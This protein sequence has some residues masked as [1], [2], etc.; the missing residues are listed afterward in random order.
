M[1]SQER[2]TSR[3]VVR[4]AHHD[5][6]AILNG[7]AWTIVV[8]TKVHVLSEDI[9]SLSRNSKEKFDVLGDLES[10]VQ[11]LRYTNMHGS[12]SRPWADRQVRLQ[13]LLYLTSE[14]AVQTRVCARGCTAAQ[15]RAPG[16]NLCYVPGKC[17]QGVLLLKELPTSRAHPH[18][19]LLPLSVI[20]LNRSPPA[21]DSYRVVEQPCPLVPRRHLVA[22]NSRV[23]LRHRKNRPSHH[24]TCSVHLTFPQVDVDL[25]VDLSRPNAML[26][27]VCSKCNARVLTK[28]LDVHERFCYGAVER[29][30]R[31]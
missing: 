7:L 2:R 10:R 28:V 26:F 17:M 8:M 15:H 4:F 13:P 20:P 14:E 11:K 18:L 27:K 21:R 16:S 3:R 9:C 25:K 29:Y 30:A 19:I 24:L 22:V 31:A 5:V 6:L 1:I 23:V 12:S